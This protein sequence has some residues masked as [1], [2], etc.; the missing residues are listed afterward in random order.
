MSERRIV[1]TD[2][3]PAAIGP[4][5]QAVLCDGWLWCSGQIPLD[6]ASGE[7]IAGDTA[8]QTQRVLDNLRA[9]LAAAGCGFADV[10]KTTI[11]LADMADFAIVNEVYGASF[12]ADPPARATVQAGALPKGARVEIEATAEC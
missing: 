11:F 8:D 5:S 7:I 1:S 3:A 4:Y 9:V 6:P 12:G 2:Q 10:V